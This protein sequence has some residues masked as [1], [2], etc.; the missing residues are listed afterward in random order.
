[1]V[2]THGQSY[3]YKYNLNIKGTDKMALIYTYEH[4]NNK[5]L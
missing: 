3:S 2:L 4:L 5:H 1:M